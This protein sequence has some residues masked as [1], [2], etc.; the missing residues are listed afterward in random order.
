MIE[1]LPVLQTEKLSLTLL[2]KKCQELNLQLKQITVSGDYFSSTSEVGADH[3]QNLIENFVNLL[4]PEGRA[5]FLNEYFHYGPLHELLIDQEIT[6]IIIHSFN[7]IWIEK[8]HRLQ[9][10][11]HHFFS[12]L[13]FKQFLQRLYL[14]IGQEPTLTHPFI[15]ATWKDCRLHIIGIYHHIQRTNTHSVRLTLRKPKLTKWSLQVLQEKEWAK[16]SEINCLKSIVLNKFNF[17]IIGATNSG[18]TSVLQALLNE[19]LPTERAIIIED[20]HEIIPPNGAS[21]NLISRLD[22]RSILPE[23]TL[24]E[25][26]KESLRMRPDRLIVGEVRGAETKDLLLALATGHQGSAGTLHASHP[27]QALMRLEMLVQMGAPQW[28]LQT[29]R[30]IL[31]LSLQYIIV[32]QRLNCGTRTLEGI[33]KLVALEESGII[34]ER[35]EL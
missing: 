21:T 31:F 28:N 25:L 34:I 32:C 14:E 7:E 23:I 27:Q 8:N 1:E 29:L 24:S 26:I 5:R 19:C 15:N 18:K 3:Y 10:C 4:P 35:I 9:A 11:P 33:Y 17:I 6:E 12:E 2:E 13:T 22:A 20:T 30:R 16:P